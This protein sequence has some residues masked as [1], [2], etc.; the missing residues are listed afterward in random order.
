MAFIH[1][2]SFL[3]TGF[4]FFIAFIFCH[5]DFCLP[6]LPLEW[7]LPIPS[8]RIHKLFLTGYSFFS[9]Q[10]VLTPHS[11]PHTRLFVH[12]C[13]FLPRILFMAICPNFVP[14][15]VMMMMRVFVWVPLF[16][17]DFFLRL[18][19]RKAGAFFPGHHHAFNVVIILICENWSRSLFSITLFSWL[20]YGLSAVVNGTIVV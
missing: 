7:Q 15:G 10:L 14:L 3:S 18:I 19:T 11:Q 20:H 13:L 9:Q 6:V 12:T 4:C 2:L 8:L 17:P 5:L 16:P 1:S